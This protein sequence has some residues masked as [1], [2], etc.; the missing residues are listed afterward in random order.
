MAVEEP[1]VVAAASFAAAII[2]RGGGFNTWATEPVMKAQIFLEGIPAGGEGAIPPLRGTIAALV[3]DYLE[4]MKARGG[5]FRDLRVQRLADVSVVRVDLFIDVR[6]A[7]GANVLNSSA[8]MIGRKLEEL[9]SARR[10]MC[11][12][13]NDATERRSGARFRLPIESLAHAGRSGLE[14]HELARRLV[15][16]GEVAGKDTTRAV[17]HNKGIMNG[18]TSLTL[19]TGNDT[20][21][22]EA[23]AHA[24]ASRDGSY[25][26]LSRYRIE[27]NELTG[28]IE[29]PLALGTVGGGVGFSPA[30]KLS[31][32]LLG[33]PNARKL[34]RIAAALGLAQ[35]FA[36]LLALVS[37]GIQKGHMRLHANRLAYL[38]GARGS[39]I[40]A[41]A[42]LLSRRGVFDLEE[43]AKAL[44]SLKGS[45]A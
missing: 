3:D 24:W 33:N 10:L 7:M 1:S 37:G 38:V 35:N 30:T 28:T 26:S 4:S 45:G 15:L 31:L 36:A 5:G 39:E 42:E 19:A 27:E 21:A 41:V 20:R 14:H 9:C 25:R 12:L 8:E 43:A 11:I 13:S 6:D 29:L 22:V 32:K 40:Q 16:A 2:G 44:S 34:S 18:I 17:T 23:A